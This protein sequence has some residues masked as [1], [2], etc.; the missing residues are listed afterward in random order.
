VGIYCFI[1]FMMIG[2]GA[3]AYFFPEQPSAAVTKEDI[4]QREEDDAE[5]AKARKEREQRI[6]TE[7]AV[8][9]K[10]SYGDV[11]ALRAGRFVEHAQ[12]E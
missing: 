10:G 1:F 8:M 11:V 6:A 12:G 4:A 5:R 9:S 7:A 2:A 3:G